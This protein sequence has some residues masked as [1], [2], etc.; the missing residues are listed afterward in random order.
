MVSRRPGRA[1][2][3]KSPSANMVARSLTPIPA[4]TVASE[5]ARA[6]R[7]SASADA[8][9]AAGIPAASVSTGHSPVAAGPVA[10]PR[11][12]LPSWHM[13]PIAWSWIPGVCGSCGAPT[14]CWTCVNA[15]PPWLPKDPQARLHLRLLWG[16][17]AS[18]LPSSCASMR[19]ALRVGAI[20][21][22]RADAALL[23]LISRGLGFTALSLSAR[24]LAEACDVQDTGGSNPAWG[25][26][27]SRATVEELV[28]SSQ[29][30]PGEVRAED[31]PSQSVV[32][33]DAVQQHPQDRGIYTR[34]SIEGKTPDSNFTCEVSPVQGVATARSENHD[35]TL[36]STDTQEAP[37]K[38]SSINPTL[39]RTEAL[40]GSTAPVT[41]SAVLQRHLDSGLQQSNQ[42]LQQHQQVTQ[43]HHVQDH[44]ILSPSPDCNPVFAALAVCLSDLHAAQSKLAPL[45]QDDMAA[46]AAAA[47]VVAGHSAGDEEKLP[48][49]I[50]P[51][52][53]QNHSTVSAATFAATALAGAL[54]TG[55]ALSLAVLPHAFMGGWMCWPLR[56]AAALRRAAAV[57]VMQQFHD[58]SAAAEAAGSGTPTG[59]AATVL[60][61]ALKC[62]GGGLRFQPNPCTSPQAVSTACLGSL[63]FPGGPSVRNGLDIPGR[64][65]REASKGFRRS[66][67]FKQATCGAAATRAAAAGAAAAAATASWGAAAA[68][69][70]VKPPLR[71]IR[72]VS[73]QTGNDTPSSDTPRMRQ[74]SNG[75]LLA[76]ATG[77]A[78]RRHASAHLV[79]S[80]KTASRINTSQEHRVSCLAETSR[81][82]SLRHT[83]PSAGTANTL[84]S[85][86][87]ARPVGCEEF[88][89]N[90]L[91]ASHLDDCT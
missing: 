10:G 36:A 1:V 41:K 73:F 5:V 32:D 30:D 58:E 2:K 88:Q 83:S 51:E 72:H 60:G 82:A 54:K 16:F 8:T 18:S 34:E 7:P 33:Q 11:S 43:A 48:Q 79:H 81:L 23:S 6:T 12:A 70:P 44:A 24:R 64:S 21:A 85:R 14:S 67:P 25:L 15:G 27:R 19:E 17:Y 62:W 3:A 35:R 84:Q 31:K 74:S 63:E 59:V 50:T 29:V 22:L 4:T 20:S 56:S 86:L 57:G 61:Q 37:K 47:E 87:S 66:T 90:P 69:P 78:I 68:V 13:G 26:E 38:E 52:K 9:P 49:M 71:Q 91:K 42:E 76:Q 40:A 77:S 65:S 39:I 89:E 45:F 28:K 75:C 53:H 46:A 55:Y 80:Q